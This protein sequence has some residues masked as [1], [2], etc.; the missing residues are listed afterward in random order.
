MISPRYPSF[1]QKVKRKFT[2][3]QS[4]LSYSFFVSW[5]LN[6]KE[7]FDRFSF[8]NWTYVENDNLLSDYGVACEIL[9]NINKMCVFFG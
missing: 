8:S 5:S 3:I 6:F 7:T 1:R 4:K 2:K 9:I